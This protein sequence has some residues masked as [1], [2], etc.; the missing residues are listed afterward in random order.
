M[1]IKRFHMELIAAAGTALLGALAAGGA[2]ELGV[3]WSSHGPQPGY[4]PFYVGLIL[5]AASAGNAIQAVVRHRREHGHSQTFLEPEQIKRLAGFF[6]PMLAFVI[7]TVFL[8]LYVGSSLYLFH[9]A[10]RQGRYNPLAA[11]GLGAGFAVALYVVFEI[12]F[13][14]PLHK[15]PIEQA[16]GIY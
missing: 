14:V 16:L 10:W 13:R 5:C 6:L 4:F 9:T 1:E 12:M 7:V 15:G 8:G 3:G 11:A 2:L